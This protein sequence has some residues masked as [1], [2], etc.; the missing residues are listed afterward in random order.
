MCVCVFI[1]SSAYV[2]LGICIGHHLHALYLFTLKPVHMESTFDVHC[3]PNTPLNPLLG[4]ARCTSNKFL[5]FSHSGRQG[6]LACISFGVP[7]AMTRVHLS[8]K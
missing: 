3:I 1:I 4:I 2:H 6:Q 8:E 7:S 5:Y